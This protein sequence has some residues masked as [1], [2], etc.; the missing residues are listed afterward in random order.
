MTIIGDAATA[1]ITNIIQSNNPKS[2][3][4]TPY[5]I[6]TAIIRARNTNTDDPKNAFLWFN[7][8]QSAVIDLYFR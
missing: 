8:F 5:D 7:L 2:A 3:Y 6:G 1:K 4:S